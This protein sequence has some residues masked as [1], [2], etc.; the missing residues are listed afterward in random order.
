[1]STNFGQSRPF[2]FP[3]GQSSSSPS[4]FG[5]QPT[6]FGSSQTAFG[7]SSQPSFFQGFG[8]SQPQ[9]STPSL[10]GQSSQTS[11]FGQ[12]SQPQQF[13]FQPQPQFNQNFSVQLST[14]NTLS[15]KDGQPIQYQTKWDEISENGQKFLL[16]LEKILIQMKSQCAE[17]KLDKRLNNNGNSD[18]SYGDGVSANIKAEI[19][20]ILAD[21][22]QRI[23]NMEVRGKGL[24]D[25]RQTKV[26]PA[27]NA[28]QD[29][30]RMFFRNKIWRQSGLKR[31]SQDQQQQQPQQQ[32]TFSGQ[33]QQQQQQQQLPQQTQFQETLYAPIYLPAPFIRESI[34]R[35]KE[36]VGIF[37]DYEM[38]LSQ[39]VGEQSLSQI[40]LGV[41]DP[42]SSQSSEDICKSLPNA[43]RNLQQY[44]KLVAAKIEKTEQR[45][46]YL[47]QSHLASI[48]GKIGVLDP[49]KEADRKERILKEESEKLELPAEAAEIPS[50]PTQHQ[51]A[52]SGTSVQQIQPPSL[53]APFQPKQSDATPT[54]RKK[55]VK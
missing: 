19:D 1:M 13:G 22:G 54:R 4:L 35:F 31:Q 6:L 16:E 33:Q 53:T 42:Q 24:D 51:I 9:Q 28:M 20:D 8:V 45:V 23:D 32:F 47:R 48:S 18:D 37:R 43:I 39:T 14:G 17:L 29:L 15:Q 52:Q 2:Q 30:V 10:F 7:Q 38:L 27:V 41:E 55:Y 50:A 40:Y 26:Q 34:N 49:F 36:S 5:S 12:P 3:F 11:L 44:L 25:L 46:Q 21:L